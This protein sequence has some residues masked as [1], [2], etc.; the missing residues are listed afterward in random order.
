[1]ISFLFIRQAWNKDAKCQTINFLT[2]FYMDAIDYLQI[3]IA[4]L[5]FIP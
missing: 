1:M 3:S 4:M 5:L 2:A